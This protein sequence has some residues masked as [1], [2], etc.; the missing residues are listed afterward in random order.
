MVGVG[1]GGGF[2]CCC[3]DPWGGRGVGVGV[4]VCCVVTSDG[5]GGGGWCGVV[6]LCSLVGLFCGGG[7]CGWF[8]VVWWFVGCPAPL[9]ASYKKK[10]DRKGKE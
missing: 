5:A 3:C 7:V 9:R 1:L 8:C 6:G 2:F 10:I 4:V